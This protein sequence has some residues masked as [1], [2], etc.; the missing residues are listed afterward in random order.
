MYILLFVYEKIVDSKK[1]TLFCPL[2]PVIGE[3][4]FSI[5]FQILKIPFV[6]P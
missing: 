3:R 5:S 4:A 1:M 2:K 6:E